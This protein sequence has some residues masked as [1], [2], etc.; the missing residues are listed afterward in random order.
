[1][2]TDKVNRKYYEAGVESLVLRH[3]KT[4]RLLKKT[5]KVCRYCDD[6]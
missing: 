3:G 5:V 6:I 2:W 1:M 4:V